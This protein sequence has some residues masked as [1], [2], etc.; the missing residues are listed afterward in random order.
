[1]RQAE[2]WREVERGRLEIEYG[3]DEIGTAFVVNNKNGNYEASSTTSSPVRQ[4]EEGSDEDQVR[5]DLLSES[6]WNL[7]DISRQP[8]SLLRH[9]SG[10]V[11][12]VT[13]PMLYLGMLYSSFCWHVE[14]HFLFSI[15]YNHMGAPK[16][17]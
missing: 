11:S 3:N 16:T 14:D 13:S 7:N 1:M 15:N 6:K 10:Q 5:A 4:G 2:Y 12:G 9:I 17:W 8:K